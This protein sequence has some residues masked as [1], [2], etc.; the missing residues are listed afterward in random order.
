MLRALPPLRCRLC[1]QLELK[2]NHNAQARSARQSSVA[3]YATAAPD[4]TTLS[5]RAQSKLPESSIS[6]LLTPETAVDQRASSTEPTIED[7]DQFLPP[8]LQPGGRFPAALKRSQRPQW[9]ASQFDKT[10]ASLMTAFSPKQ[11]RNLAKEAGLLKI[12]STSKRRDVLERLMIEH[13]GW[14]H[15]ERI[16]KAPDGSIIP[17]TEILPLSLVELTLLLA[18]TAGKLAPLSRT[19]DVEL[20]I[21]GEPP[22]LRATGAAH[23]LLRFRNYVKSVQKAIITQPLALPRPAREELFQSIASHGP[24]LIEATADKSLIKLTTKGK[25]PF[26]RARHRIYQA[27]ALDE[28]AEKLRIYVATSDEHMAYYPHGL[29]E[30]LP[31]HAESTQ[32]A[33]LQNVLPATAMTSRAQRS[34]I[35]CKTEPAQGLEASLASNF[36]EGDTKLRLTAGYWLS[37]ADI[38]TTPDTVRPR[39]F[40][41]GYASLMSTCQELTQPSIDL[42]PVWSSVWCQ[43]RIIG[44][45]CQQSQQRSSITQPCDAGFA[46][47]RRSRVL[48]API[49]SSR[50]NFRLPHQAP[51]LG[52]TRHSC[53]R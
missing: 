16:R 37:N 45:Q 46:T 34:T 19:Y 3:R 7:F 52:S 4:H 51:H 13:W 50:R 24:A 40:V 17:E 32:L 18:D 42:R 30:R 48:A 15:P 53:A 43:Q 14:Q 11:V 44:H 12:K 21:E 33:R 49:S 1:R 28:A 38:S 10:L 8:F 36:I 6:P 9:I 29:Y 35:M 5:A 22:Q 2:Q 27:C 25:A 26:M 23:H 20:A 47:W 39:L 41:P 31:W